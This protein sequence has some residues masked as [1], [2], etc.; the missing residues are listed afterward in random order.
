MWYQGYDDNQ[1]NGGTPRMMYATSTDGFNWVKPQNLGLVEYDGST[2]N[3]IILNYA[4]LEYVFKDTNPNAPDSE[5]YKMISGG[6]T[7]MRTSP[8]GINWSPEG[9]VLWNHSNWDTQKQAW[10]D[11]D[12]GKYVI[13]VRT[14]TSHLGGDTEDR[15]LIPL[16]FVDPI[17]SDPPV[18]DPTTFRSNRMLARIEVDDIMQPWEVNGQP[19]GTAR[20]I[21]S[22]DELDPEQSDVYHPGGVY[23]Y[24]YADDAY[25]MFPWVYE[26]WPNSPV[27]NDG[28][29]NTQ[30]AASRNG[31]NYMRY[32]RE[33][34]L[35]RGAEGE[36]DYGD[37]DPLG[38]FFR[39]GD[40]LYQYYTT[41]PWS[42]GGYRAMTDE[43]QRDPE[44]WGRSEY[45]LAKQRLDGFVSADAPAEG[46]TFETPLLMF[47]G[48]SL[49]LNIEVLLGGS[50]K[51]AILDENGIP[52]PGFGLED[53]DLI[54]VDDVDYIVTWNGEYSLP[55]LAG[56]PIGLLFEMS[57]TKLYAFQF[58][59]QPVP[60]DFNND[61]V[62]NELDAGIL[63]SYWQ[64]IGGANLS[65][66][67]AN[68]D[69]NVDDLDATIVAAN[70]TG[71]TANAAVPEPAGL[72]LLLGVIPILC[73][74]RRR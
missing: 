38:P 33:V 34:Y 60:G 36:Y 55:V 35:P 4:K 25:F 52:L 26:H 6:S 13:Q 12:L 42:H 14:S 24:P 63:A 58:V 8:D 30:F 45:H 23:K 74:F 43:E 48:D 69:G 61:G 40:Y 41:W 20:T 44:N 29:L 9:P 28:I 15:E 17:P 67:D 10:W 39:Q 2:D 73:L 1:W 64:T 62:V 54:L 16:G 51:V 37:T 18:V 56:T 3:N 66:G 59:P 22:G 11:E 7:R 46:G 68:G 70:W 72:T 5:R 57:S 32:D 49:L 53:C 71:T 21:M 27:P 31:W 50:A 65:M 47:E 19:V